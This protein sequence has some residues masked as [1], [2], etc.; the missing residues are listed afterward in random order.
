MLQKV[1]L[2]TLVAN[3]FPEFIQEEYPALTSF[4]EAYYK[5]L[6]QTN[7][8]NLSNYRDI[9]ETLDAFIVHFKNELNYNGFYTAPE[10]DRF[11]LKKIKE[12]YSA[13]GSEESYRL[14]FKLLFN[15]DVEIY[16]PYK[17][18]LRASDGKWVQDN[19]LFVIPESGD[20]NTLLNNTIRVLSGNKRVNYVVVKKIKKIN[21]SLYEVFIENN[22]YLNNITITST[23]QFKDT[24]GNEFIGKIS[25]TIGTYEVL[26]PG[27]GFKVGE[28]L[29]INTN[30]SNGTT[31]TTIKVDKIDANGGIKRISFIKFGTGYSYDFYGNAQSKFTG[32]PDSIIS[33]SK[34]NINLLSL[35]SKTSTLGFIDEGYIAT[36]NYWDLDYADNTYVGDIV[37]TFRTEVAYTLDSTSNNTNNTPLEQKMALIRFNLSPIAKYQGYYIN[38][39]GFISDAIYIENQ[40]YYQPYAYQI[41]IDEALNSYKN[42][43][44]SYLHT[45]GTK[46][47]AEYQL[48]NVINLSTE[49]KSLINYQLIQFVDNVG[50]SD[51]N[52]KDLIKSAN[53]SIITSDYVG[54]ALEKPLF[55][56]TTILDSNSILTEKPIED[57][58]E[59]IDNI[60]AID[61][62]KE[63]SDL[64]VSD[65]S[66][67]KDYA[68]NYDDAVKAVTIRLYNVDGYVEDG[69][70]ALDDEEFDISIFKPV[71]D[72]IL[73][74]DTL[75]TISTEKLVEDSIESTENASIIALRSLALED[76]IS[77]LDTNSIDTSKEIFDTAILDDNT[78][79]DATKGISDLV[80][81]N[82]TN[83]IDTTKSISDTTLLSDTASKSTL[84]QSSDQIISI[85]N[86]TINTIK[87][88]S[89]S[90]VLDDTTSKSAIKGISD[91]VTQTDTTL[92]SATKGISDSITSVDNNAKNYQLS[93]NDNVE[94]ITSYFY[95]IDNYAEYGYFA[96]D[97]ES[98]LFAV[99]KSLSLSDGLTINDELI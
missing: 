38:N 89:D 55:D 24:S 41:K 64:V 19:S 26:N 93:S 34:N 39:D 40:D 60:N 49:I 4:I 54:V 33:I 73:L 70:L 25:P 31:S 80:I 20:I 15:K 18:V 75:D 88:I 71:S 58:V 8:R 1:K 56:D 42:I 72:D 76:S 45:A 68:A 99:S 14:L 47:F 81:P 77:I 28:L 97:E 86:N 50:P 92:K 69:Y 82:D 21:E 53:D 10:N 67:V 23:I 16:Y 3:Q 52:V 95:N 29:T 9:D 35:P 62:T 84:K 65:D 83:S 37:Q 13:K 6:E 44:K 96:D 48:N 32:A 91:S 36:C 79:I 57:L 7:A 30:T 46:L 22:K 74:S 17:S 59:S 2:S 51:E 61:V 85:D 11:I 66:N 63:I 90:V 98:V 94:A 43:I 27:L 5:F 78:L 87:G 12:I